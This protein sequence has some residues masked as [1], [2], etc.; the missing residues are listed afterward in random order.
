MEVLKERWFKNGEGHRNRSRLGSFW[1]PAMLVAFA[2]GVMP[3]GSASASGLLVA[4]GGFGGRLLIKEQVVNV[5]INNGIAVTEVNQV[6][7]NT[8]SRIVEALYTFP[9]PVNASVSNFSMIIN[10]KEMIGEVV[11]KKRARQIYQSYKRTKKDPGLLEQVDYKTFEMRVFPIQPHAEQHIKVVYY[12]PLDVD[13]DWSTYVFPLATST[14]AENEKTTGKFALTLD[15]KSE[16]PVKKITS[17]SHPNEFVVVNH[18]SDY[19]Q[20]SMEVNEGDLSRDIVIAFQS[21]RAKTGIDLITSKHEGEDGYFL[22]SLTAGEELE[23]TAGG[24][25]YV[26][27]VDISGSMRNDG[28]LML[29]QGAVEAFVNSLGEEDRFD[30]MVFNNAPKMLFSKLEDVNAEAKEKA[31]KFLGEQYAKGGTALR[32]A[33]NAAYRYKQPDRE[34]NVVVL[35]DGMTEAGGQKELLKLIS[36]APAS[37]KVFCV[38]IG[39]E[40]NRPLL[41]QLARDAGG[42]ATFISHEDD[43]IRQAEAF[44]RKLVHPVAT[45]LVLA[46]DGVPVYDTMPGALPNLYHGKPIRMIGRYKDFGEGNVTLKGTVMGRP[47]EQS[48]SFDFP[49]LNADN[50]QIDRMWAWYRVQGLMD[51]M[52]KNGDSSNLINDIVNLCEGYSIV[53]EYASFIV[54]E[55]DNEYKRWKIDRRNATRIQR[56][57]AARKKLDE[58][59]KE[60]RENSMANLGPIE[61]DSKVEEVAKKVSKPSA[62]AKRVANKPS[63]RGQDLNFG[64]QPVSSSKS[65]TPVNNSPWRST[66]QRSSSSN[67]SS[68]GSSW[69]GGGGGAIDPITGLI[70]AGMAGVAAARRK[71]K[72]GLKKETDVS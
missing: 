53:S 18:S 13:H 70:A 67:R 22:M 29:S 27:V 9:V 1:L 48:V 6:F 21:K 54:L 32:P 50:P 31:T 36:D 44:R 24:M 55:N 68:S 2:L 17:H 66:A 19:A 72:G 14:K 52:R 47:F 5:T 35:S 60:L 3:V 28:K 71:R 46:I 25:D 4:K 59:L 37:S 45:D 69:G 49:R 12:Q 15:I 20:A 51:E 41:T 63:P 38:G 33:M 26:F 61:S 64:T 62:P 58:S 42:L 65:A 34:L 16:I 7:L 40:V 23:N 11:E 8:E 39:N 43:F 10:G 56:D 30:V 57:R